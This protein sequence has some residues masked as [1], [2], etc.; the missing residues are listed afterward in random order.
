MLFEK[1]SCGVEDKDSVY[2]FFFVF[3]FVLLP[4]TREI[5]KTVIF[6]YYI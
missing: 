2:D 6:S 1:N 3:F 4:I 5:K